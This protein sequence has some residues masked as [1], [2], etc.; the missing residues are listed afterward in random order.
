[1]YLAMDAESL[2]SP[3]ILLFDSFLWSFIICLILHFM[4][5]FLGSSMVFTNYSFLFFAPTA[6]IL[7]L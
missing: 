4:F 1:M 3:W 7:V 2:C 5:Y 6:L